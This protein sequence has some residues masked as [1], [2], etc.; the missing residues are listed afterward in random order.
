MDRELVYIVRG[1]SGDYSDFT[2]WDLAAF[3][4]A[5]AAQALCNKMNGWLAEYGMLRDGNNCAAYRERR[6]TPNECPFDPG[7]H[8]VSYGGGEYEV[9]AVEV[10]S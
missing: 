9:W 1:N 3:R 10:R 5:T 4:E 2:Q 8:G 6:S 7:F